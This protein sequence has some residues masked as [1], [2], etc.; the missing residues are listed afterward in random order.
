MKIFVVETLCDY[1]VQ[2]GYST[3][4]K[5]AEEKAK[6][7]QKIFRKKVWVEEYTIGKDNWV[8]FNGD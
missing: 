1:T 8:E 7:L 6:E 5:V 3:S 2:L 4:R